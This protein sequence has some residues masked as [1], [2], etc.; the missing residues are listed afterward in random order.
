MQFWVFLTYFIIRIGDPKCTF[1]Y[2]P[3]QIK[4]DNWDKAIVILNALIVI[5][6]MMK[7]LFLMQSTSTFALLTTLVIE[8]MKAV[9]PFLIY[10]FLW[11]GFFAIMSI[12]LGGNLNNA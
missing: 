3:D 6:M 4:A 11:V 2:A 1:L 12:I 8:V 7:T 10:F 9:V 5:Q